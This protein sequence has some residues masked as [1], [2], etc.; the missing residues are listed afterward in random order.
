MI[1][2]KNN[3]HCRRLGWAHHQIGNIPLM[4]PN[5]RRAF[6][7]L[8]ASL[9]V[10]PS[11]VYAN[12]FHVWRDKSGRKH[13][14]NI[15]PHG[16]TAEGSLRKAYNPNS[17]LAQHHAMRKSLQE[18]SAQIAHQQAERERLENQPQVNESDTIIRAPKEGIMGLRDLIKLERRGGRYS[19][20]P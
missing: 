4:T 2:M 7:F 10:L 9:I 14:S 8:I 13:I 3:Q 18:Q 11:Q 16:F 1:A 20:K 19:E 6:L 5:L 12:E 15:P 17:L